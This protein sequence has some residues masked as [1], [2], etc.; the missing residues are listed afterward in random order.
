MELKIFYSAEE[1]KTRK[2]ENRRRE[3]E[4][5]KERERT[6]KRRGEGGTNRERRRKT[7]REN[8]HRREKEKKSAG[9]EKFRGKREGDRRDR[10]VVG[11]ERRKGK[12]E[13][14]LAFYVS[15]YMKD[16][17]TYPT[18]RP[19]DPLLP[20][21]RSE[22]TNQHATSSFSRRPEPPLAPVTHLSDYVSL[23][24]ALAFLPLLHPRPQLSRPPQPD[25]KGF[26]ML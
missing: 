16:G 8:G 23:S 6:D 25:G 9:R 19:P 3:R 17:I 18:N 20:S 15:N 21:F 26:F 11:G 7:V 5:E 24:P 10:E 12:G 1:K 14:L 2:S 22:P 4:R 13:N